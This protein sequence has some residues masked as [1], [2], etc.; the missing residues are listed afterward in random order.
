MRI[1]TLW[2]PWATL[3]ALGL[4]QYETRSWGTT[5]RG[6]L[7]IHAAKRPVLDTEVLSIRYGVGV[8]GVSVSDLEKLDK[9]LDQSLPL[10][11]VVAIANL[12]GC[13]QMGRRRLK[14]I[15]VLE[16]SVGYWETGRY[17]WKL[18]NVQRLAAPISWRGGQGLRVAPPQLKDAIAALCPADNPHPCEPEAPLSVRFS[19]GDRVSIPHRRSTQ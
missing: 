14:G 10:G 8:G 16:Q 12:S 5:Y 11:C 13:F 9:T 17:A 15:S 3:I 4:K 1:I 6:P 19:T 2:Q 7:L 18:E